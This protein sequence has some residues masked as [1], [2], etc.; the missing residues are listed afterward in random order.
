MS[1]AI[2][3]IFKYGNQKL[4]IKCNYSEKIIEACKKFTN[5]I[6]TDLD[7]KIVIFNDEQIDLN[8]DVT[9]LEAINQLSKPQSPN[10][11]FKIKLIDDNDK[12]Y[13]VVV[14]YQNDKKVIKLK[15]GDKLKKIFDYIKKNTKSYFL[16]DA[17][18]LTSDD[19]E[20][21][22]SQVANSIDK[23]SKQM[24][25]IAYDKEDEDE[26]EEQIKEEDTQDKSKAE[27]INN[28]IVV[29]NINNEPIANEN[30]N[31]VERDSISNDIGEQVKIG[32]NLRRYLLITIQ[33]IIII[34]F[35][36]IGCILGINEAFT[37]SVGTMLGTFIPVI[38]VLGGMSV[39]LIPFYDED[40]VEFFIKIIYLVIY[41]FSITFLCFL[42]TKF[43]DFKYIVGEIF[44][45]LSN[46]IVMTI[47]SFSISS[48]DLTCFLN[49]LPYLIELIINT[50]IIVLYYFLMS[51][52]AKII[53]NMSIISL[54]F[55]IYIAIINCV[56][57]GNNLSLA[58]K[59]V[60]CFEYGNMEFLLL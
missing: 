6:S 53:I 60:S 30:N 41:T 8:S 29:N 49:T 28:P 3:V 10:E 19:F 57:E 18:V 40:D 51:K 45:F 12:L 38:V 54:A 14:N 37:K 4:S 33:F 5:Q 27:E 25:L 48:V 20:R 15:K 32:Q 58:W 42:L 47:Y 52:N 50:I 31:L 44:I 1:D 35:V 43:T 7:T 55:L 22:F 39:L 21:R 26:D 24:S 36:W 13:K 23:E 11:K 16:K 56:I 9:F 17:D 34:I 2:D 59:S 46:M